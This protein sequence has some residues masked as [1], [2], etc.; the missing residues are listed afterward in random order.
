MQC[1]VTHF[2]PP[3]GTT[4]SLLLLWQLRLCWSQ[5]VESIPHPEIMTYS[6]ISVIIPNHNYAQYLRQAIDSALGQSY[7]RVEV[8]VVDD[9]STDESIAI[10][11]SYGD[12]I[13]CF[14]QRNQG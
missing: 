3:S 11:R 8:I 9:G 13:R 10:L 1:G 7:P 4:L 2:S 14:Q 5:C 12:R 6:L